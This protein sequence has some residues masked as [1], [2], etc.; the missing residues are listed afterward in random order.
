MR[1]PLLLEENFLLC[2]QVQCHSK[3][4]NFYMKALYGNVDNWKHLSV[5]VNICSHK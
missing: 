4:I 5:D 2:K 3:K 1:K